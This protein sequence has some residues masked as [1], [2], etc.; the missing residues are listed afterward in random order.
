MYHSA[1]KSDLMDTSNP[2]QAV[3]HNSTIIDWAFGE[4]R[5][6]GRRA[7]RQKGGTAERQKGGR[8]EGRNGRTAE[9]QNGSRVAVRMATYLL[10]LWY[11]DNDDDTF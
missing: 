11:T 5:Q 7:E 10:H 9:R 4:G 6:N 3:V 1:R 2:L 8:A